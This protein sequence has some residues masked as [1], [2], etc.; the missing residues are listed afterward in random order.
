MNVI[1]WNI[2]AAKGVDEVT[3]VE[4]IA[5]V[6]QQ[7]GDVD[8]ICCQEVMNCTI[9]GVEM[10][11]AE[12]LAAHF[13]D[14]QPFFGAAIDRAHNTSR[15]QFGNL[16]LCRPAVQQCS[17]HRLPQPPDPDKLCMPRQ[18]VELLVDWR[19]APLRLVTTHLDYFATRQRSAQAHYLRQWHRDTNS[20][21]D[22][23]APAGGEM[24]FAALPE[25]RLSLYCG[26]FNLA[27]QSDDYD[28]LTGSRTPST[29][30]ALIDCWW[31]LYPE[32]PHAPTCG[33]HDRIQWPEGPHCRDFFFASKDLAPHISALAVD[34][35][36]DA[37]DHQPIM[38]TLA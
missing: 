35:D 17:Y 18:A 23:P 19:G 33:I 16:V 4:R 13:P 24:Q 8:I 14:H 12:A 27:P 3:S 11:Q 28:T 6:I 32:Q 36:T 29:D 37:S 15:L 20:R 10:N 7:F 25:T 2:Q 21:H 38:L 5:A 22:N 34:V 26:D 1:S 31:Q 30:D 9:D